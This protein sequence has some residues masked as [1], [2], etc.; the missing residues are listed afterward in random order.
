MASWLAMRFGGVMNSAY[1]SIAKAAQCLSVMLTACVFLVP[2]NGFAEDYNNPRVSSTTKQPFEVVDLNS[3][4]HHSIDI[5]NQWLPMRPGTRWVYE[6][7][8]VEDNG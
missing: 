4:D 7:T 3:F 2:I 1:T 8:T 6:G 5:D